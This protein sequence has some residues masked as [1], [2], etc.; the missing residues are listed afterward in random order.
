MAVYTHLGAEDL[1]QLIAHYDVGRL[2]SFKGIAEG[3]SNSN[4]L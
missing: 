1:A 2:V 3:V 4:W